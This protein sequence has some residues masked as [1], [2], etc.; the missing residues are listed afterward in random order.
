[1]HLDHPKYFYKS[2]FFLYVVSFVMCSV[3]AQVAAETL[4]LRQDWQPACDRGDL[5]MVKK[6]YVHAKAEYSSALE[7][8][9]YFGPASN[10]VQ[11]SLLRLEYALVSV[12]KINEA[13]P[14]YK[15]S[16]D[17]AARNFGHSGQKADP[18]VLVRMSDLAEAYEKESSRQLLGY[19][20][21]HSIRL[22]D[23]CEPNHE[24]QAKTFATLGLLCANRKDYSGAKAMYEMQMNHLAMKWGLTSVQIVNPLVNVGKMQELLGQYAGAEASFKLARTITSGDKHTSSSGLVKTLNQDIKRVAE[25]SKQT[26]KT[27]RDV[28][29]QPPNGK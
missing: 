14:Y 23:Y 10:Q 20:L 19:C 22:R 18:E 5:C 21:N 1:M 6:D 29:I 2:L 7:A 26:R 9:E 16:M 15:R 12:H 8:A 28:K 27:I 25:A 3:V 13:E 4:D 11:L 17:L 24:K